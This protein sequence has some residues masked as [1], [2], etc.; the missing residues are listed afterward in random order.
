MI[1]DWDVIHCK[2]THSAIYIKVKNDILDLIYFYAERLKFV[3]VNVI[4]ICLNYIII[5]HA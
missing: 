4:V 2:W 1:W 5:Q 3:Y